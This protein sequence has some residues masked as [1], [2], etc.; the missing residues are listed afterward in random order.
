MWALRNTLKLDIRRFKFILMSNF[1]NDFLDSQNSWRPWGPWN[2]CS[3]TCGH[4]FQ[5]RSRT[6]KIDGLCVGQR[7]EQVPCVNPTPCL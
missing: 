2:S 7:K 3:A 6:C 4:G 1:L 5:F